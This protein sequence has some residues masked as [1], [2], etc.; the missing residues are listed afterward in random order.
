M[1]STSNGSLPVHDLALLFPP[2]TDEE[3]SDLRADISANGI[4]QP[5]A[6]WR[7]S[8]I[9]GRHRYQICRELGIEPPIQEIDD[10][11]DP[12][13][14]VL[15]ANMHRRHLNESQRGL[16]WAD[17]RSIAGE[18]STNPYF[19]SLTRE[20]AGGVLGVGTGTLTLSTRVVR[21]GAAGVK[22]AVRQGTLRVWDAAQMVDRPHEVQ[23]FAVRAVEAGEART[24]VA[25]VNALDRRVLA[26]NPPALPSGVYRTVVIDP[27]WPM[28][29][30]AREV[31]PNQQGFDYPTMSI[32][33][34]AALDVPSRL[35]DDAHVFLWTTQKFLPAAFD[36]LGSWNL[37]YRFTM[38]WHKPGGIQIH[39]YPQFNCEFVVVGTK[40]S[41][42]FTDLK[43][44]NV[45]FE[46][47]RQGHSVKPAE[48]YDVLRRVTASPR[49]DMFSRR[50]IDGFET[51]GNEA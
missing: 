19:S 20:E 40:G 35:A 39:N 44:F 18:E 48:F 27:P 22:E 38:V 3:L 6:V 37:N 25:A 47:D 1:T 17:L 29:K 15:S 12:V 14:F 13:R 26:E 42:I 30:I 36:L 8:I 34:I 4:Q 16:I 7:G 41:P 46:A 9:D 33:E 2:M 32:D 23:E 21:N 28:T 43:S 45:A 5:I 31:R 11:A 50:E 51:W 10:D 49:L 24:A